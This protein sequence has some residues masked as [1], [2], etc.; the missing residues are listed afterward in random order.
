MPTREAVEKRQSRHARGEARRLL[1]FFPMTSSATPGNGADACVRRRAF[2]AST[3]KLFWDV[4]SRSLSVLLA[5]VLARRLG[6]DGY[7][8]FAVLWYTAWMLAQATDLG[9]HVVG[10]RR[11]SRHF[12]AKTLHGILGAKALLSGLAAAGI[13]VLLAT[14]ALDADAFPLALLLFV[15]LAGSWV[16]L[17]GVV[18]RSRGGVAR[19][20]VLLVVLRSSWLVASVLAVWRSTDLRQLA[21]YLA[22]AS[23][24]ALF[25]AAGV[26]RR[27]AAGSEAQA[28]TPEPGPLVRDILPFAAASVLTLIYLRADLLILAVLG[29]PV[30]VGLFA[31]S[32]RLFEATFVISAAIVAGAFPLLVRAMGQGTHGPLI[33]LLGT[34][35]LAAAFPIGTVFFALAGPTLT[36]VYGAGF[37]DAAPVLAWLGLAIPAVYLNALTTHLLIAAERPRRL[38]GAVLVR[39]SV[40]ILLDVILIPTHGASG[41]AMAVCAAEWSLTAASLAFT[42]DLLRPPVGSL[43]TPERVHE[44]VETVS[45][46]PSGRMLSP[47]DVGSP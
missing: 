45:P 5:I 13:A 12:R 9:L 16:E 30:E 14:N 41:A 4:S 8:R 2:A 22:L 43:T 17:G 10:L 27:R 37:S 3:G 28:V 20:G 31:A 32:F 36:A 29:A 7:G 15:Q 1:F 33:R 19:E 6:A 42:L 23:L 35:L 44:T 47:T 26:L 18:L 25:A 40:G 39:F 11:L 34:W 38:V 46:T 21:I 24:P